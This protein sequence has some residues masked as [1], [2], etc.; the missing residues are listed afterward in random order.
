LIGGD[1]DVVPPS[2][3]VSGWDSTCHEGTNNVTDVGH[4]TF[5]VSE[6]QLHD[7][8]NRVTVLKGVVQLLDRQ[9]QRSDW[10]VSLLESKIE[11]I[12][13]EISEI[14]AALDGISSPYEHE[15]VTSASQH[16]LSDRPG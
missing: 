16:R 1:D 4:N 8:T 11:T 2:F 14:E 7:L 15:G 5:V 3:R 6:A 9:M 12:L 10:K 13:A